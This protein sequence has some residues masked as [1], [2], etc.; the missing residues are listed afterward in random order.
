ML[1]WVLEGEW[2]NINA[3]MN[4]S[5][6]LSNL[7]SH[8]SQTSYSQP[9]PLLCWGSGWGWLGLHSNSPTCC[10]SLLSVFPLPLHVFM[11]PAQCAHLDGSS[12]WCEA[13]IAPVSQRVSPLVWVTSQE[14][15]PSQCGASVSS[16]L[17]SL[18]KG[19]CADGHGLLTS[20]AACSGEQH[21]G[22]GNGH[23]AGRAACS[24]TAHNHTRLCRAQLLCITQL[25]SV[26]RQTIMRKKK[27]KKQSVY[28][29]CYST[30]ISQNIEIILK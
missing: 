3:S 6:P 14:Q 7:P 29:C 22:A 27:E 19:I 1:I 15:P 25:K 9:I 23:R 11:F 4:S 18:L 17:L 8:G 10:S 13:P 24:P 16:Q 30:R 20:R 21:H 26:K 28:P 12:P 5:P 2:E